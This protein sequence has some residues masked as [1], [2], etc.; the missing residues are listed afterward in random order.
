MTENY[1]G[2]LKTCVLYF[3]YC[4]HVVYMFH[5]LMST[6]RA[7]DLFKVLFYIQKKKKKKLWPSFEMKNVHEMRPI[8]Y[9]QELS[10][11]QPLPVNHEYCAYL[12]IAMSHFD[13]AYVSLLMISE[14]KAATPLIAWEPM[15]LRYAMLIF[16]SPSSSTTDM[17]L[18]FP[19]S[20]GYLAATSY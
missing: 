8:I 9:D 1:L 15:M 16:F 11:I 19:S 13:I 12:V 18:N 17:R 14:C 4:L 10:H 20:P 7:D 2:E 3:K 5:A 6:Y